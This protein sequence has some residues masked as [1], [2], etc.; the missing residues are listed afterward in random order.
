[1]IKSYDVMSPDGISINRMKT[2]KTI[3]EAGEALDNFLKR[4]EA[5]GYYSSNDGRIPLEQLA[6]H[7]NLVTIK[8]TAKEIVDDQVNESFEF[9][10]DEL[11]DMFELSSG[12]ISPNQVQRLEK[13]QDDLSDLVLEWVEQN[14]PE[15]HTI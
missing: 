4:Y 9:I 5:Q 1:M 6:F 11:K 3:E 10:F 13:F 7:C 14:S 2:Y 8:M 15:K 12:D